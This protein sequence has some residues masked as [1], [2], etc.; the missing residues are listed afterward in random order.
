MLDPG[1]PL[2]VLYVGQ[3]NQRK[4]I[5]YLLGAMEILGHG[6]ELRVVGPVSA[7]MRERIH[8]AALA[9]VA[10]VGSVDQSRLAD[11]YR[12]AH[13]LV[14]PSLGEGFALVVPEAMSTG[15]PCIVTERTG[16]HEVV[17][18]GINGM[19]VPVQ[20]A[21]GIADA[22]THI[23]RDPERYGAMS[24]QA[25]TDA[26]TLTWSRFGKDAVDQLTSFTSQE[27]KPEEPSISATTE[28]L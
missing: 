18:D 8:R 2:R 24:A 20:D 10:I 5:S 13:V 6:F 1:A 28:L 9:N 7:A 19:I 23:V 22:L 26:S 21:R 17:R 15:L 12:R 4:G 3:V 27:V 16:S 14:L 25:A 11:E